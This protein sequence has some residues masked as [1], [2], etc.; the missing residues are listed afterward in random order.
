[1]RSYVTSAL[2][3]RWRLLFAGIG[4]AAL[5]MTPL[6][7]VEIWRSGEPPALPLLTVAPDVA[8]RAT[9]GL[10]VLL[11]LVPAAAAEEVFFRG[12]MLKQTAAFT[13][14]V[15]ALLVINGVVFSAMHG[16][17]SP[18]A[19]LTRA[20]MGAGFAYMTLRLGGIEFATGAHAA[21]NILIVLFLQ[22]LT[23]K[24]A[25]APD[26]TAGSTLEDFALA[27][28]YVA[29]TEAVVRWT[30]LRRLAGVDPAPEGPPA[31]AAETFS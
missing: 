21:N 28:A 13:R 14:N 31:S 20:V 27:L 9:Y 6:F 3:L 12:W 16:D 10:A 18:D 29:I 30:P 24:T 8:G 22:P 4:L 1:M 25:V 19:F 7:L 2:R 26:M 11:L 23:L 17:F 5:A 15:T